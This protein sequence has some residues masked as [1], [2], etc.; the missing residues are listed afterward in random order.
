MSEAAA[1]DIDVRDATGDDL[2]VL[3]EA[4]RLGQSAV[5]D[6]RG[7][8]LDTLLKGRGEPIA[9]SFAED[10]AEQDTHVRIGTGDGSFLGYCVMKVQSLRD[11][12]TLGVVTD[13][14][15]HPDAR[16]IGVG[17]ALM[18]D[19]ADRAQTL[20]CIGIDARALPGDRATKNFF[21]S[22]GLVARA[23]E[24]HKRF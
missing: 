4:H 13:L 9:E 16:G 7:G 12:T 19:A 8:P 23:I 24:V 15:V 6:A 22:F 5:V 1:I 20:G 2:E 18:G 10:I 17:H 11:G 3:S 14:W 21:E